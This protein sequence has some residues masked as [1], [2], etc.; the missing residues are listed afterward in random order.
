MLL[1]ELFY[2]FM[3]V[4][5]VNDSLDEDGDNDMY[6]YVRYEL[7]NVI[8]TKELCTNDVKNFHKVE[9]GDILTHSRVLK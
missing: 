5:N 9:I 6:I 7:W 4:A 2:A 1:F 8:Y 3:H